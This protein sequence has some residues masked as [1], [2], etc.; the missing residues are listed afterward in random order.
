[1]KIKW[2]FTIKKNFAPAKEYFLVWYTG[3]T[4]DNEPDEIENATHNTFA[5]V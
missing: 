5:K 3:Y 4:N 2:K 1:M